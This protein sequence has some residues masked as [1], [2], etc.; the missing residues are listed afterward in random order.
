MLIMYL[1]N[2]HI[3]LEKYKGIHMVVHMLEEEE[4]IHM[5]DQYHMLE[6]YH[7]V[8]QYHMLVVEQY[9]LLLNMVVE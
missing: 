2:I 1:S 3:M 7:M 9:W 8:E 4:Y 6:Q 5:V